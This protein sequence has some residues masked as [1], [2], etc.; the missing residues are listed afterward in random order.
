MIES[1]K[2][3]LEGND[4]QDYNLAFPEVQKPKNPLLLR[5]WL[6]KGTGI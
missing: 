2:N 3:C 5:V 6:P 1:G 4:L